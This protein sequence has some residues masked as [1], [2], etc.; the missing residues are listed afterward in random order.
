MKS[1]ILL[2]VFLLAGCSH[3]ASDSW[4]GQDKAQH[5]LA[6]ALLTA[7]GTEVAQHQGYSPTRSANIGLLFSISLGAGKELWDSRS[8]GTGWSWKDFAWDIAGAATGYTVWR[9][10]EY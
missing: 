6:S 4:S 3:T 2:I 7:A 5:F 10:A 9:M 8:A 1:L